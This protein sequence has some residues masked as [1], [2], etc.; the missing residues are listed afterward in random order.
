MDVISILATGRRRCL[1]NELPEKTFIVGGIPE[2]SVEKCA[3]LNATDFM[4]KVI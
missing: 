3:V 4:F 2:Q 1:A